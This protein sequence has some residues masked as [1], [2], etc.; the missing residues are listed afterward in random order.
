MEKN[1]KFQGGKRGW[2]GRGESAGAEGNKAL[3][4]VIHRHDAG[5]REGSEAGR[6]VVD[7]LRSYEKVE[8]RN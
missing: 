7:W 8:V 5:V 3:R 6:K 1:S 2:E 4:E